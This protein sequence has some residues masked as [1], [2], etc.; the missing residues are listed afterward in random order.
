MTPT[1]GRGSLEATRSERVISVRAVAWKDEAKDDLLHARLARL[2]RLPRLLKAAAAQ[3]SAPAFGSFG[4][5]RD[6]F[7]F[8]RSSRFTPSHIASAAATNTDE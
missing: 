8:S 1:A 4:S 3:T 7:S 5:W 2:P 6:F